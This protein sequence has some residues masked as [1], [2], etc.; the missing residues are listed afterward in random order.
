MH[1]LHSKFHTIG[2][3]DPNALYRE[4]YFEVGER[5]ERMVWE[6]ITRNKK[7]SYNSY[8]FSYAAADGERKTYTWRRTV[9]RWYKQLKEMELRAG[10]VEEVEGEVLAVWKGTNRW[11]VKRGSLFIRKG[12]EGDEKEKKRWEVMVILTAFAIIENF[13]RRGK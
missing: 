7:W 12:E 11:N 5:R 13:Q 2:L 9:D 6:R 1:S 10:S 4:D 3:G 8:T